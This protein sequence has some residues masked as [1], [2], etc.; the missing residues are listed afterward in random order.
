ML[1]TLFKRFSHFLKEKKK[2][3][4]LILKMY[5]DLRLQKSFLNKEISL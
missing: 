3:A 2:D 5:I 1:L 4:R